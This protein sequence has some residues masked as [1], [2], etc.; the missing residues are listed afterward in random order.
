MEDHEQ[1]EFYEREDDPIIIVTLTPRQA[2]LICLALQ[3]QGIAIV[4]EVGDDPT[5][6]LAV[7]ATIRHMQAAMTTIQS[8]AMQAISGGFAANVEDELA[9]FI[10]DQEDRKL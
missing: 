9:A 3:G 5:Q 8:A 6:A 7:A 1:D 2:A 10:A 4:R